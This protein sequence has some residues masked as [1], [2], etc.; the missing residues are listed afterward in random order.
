MVA[1][2]WL[3]CNRVGAAR[4]VAAWQQRDAA[5]VVRRQCAATVL[6]QCCCTLTRHPGTGNDVLSPQALSPD[7]CIVAPSTGGELTVASPCSSASP[8]THV[9]HGFQYDGQHAASTRSARRQHMPAAHAQ[10][11]ASTR[12]QG[13]AVSRSPTPSRA[14][15]CRRRT[16]RRLCVGVRRCA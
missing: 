13:R 15:P 9:T 16:A 4:F 3:G 14:A 7:D 11:A 2:W 10:C 8:S 12:C 1:A 5:A 6:L